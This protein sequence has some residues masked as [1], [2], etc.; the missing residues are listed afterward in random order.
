MSIIIDKEKCTG[1]RKC[2]GICPGS[3]IEMGADGK[4][5]IKYPRDCW[6]CASC[7]KE[8]KYGAISL[9]LGADIG[10]AGS[11]LRVVEEGD[12]VHWKIEKRNGETTVID[13]NRKDSNNY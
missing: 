1:C 7:V 13:V 9:Y 5:F 6:A 3:L 8:C 12:I 11:T 4:A 10:G 2:A